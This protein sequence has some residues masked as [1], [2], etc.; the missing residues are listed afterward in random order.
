MPLFSVR[1]LYFAKATVSECSLSL[2]LGANT[3]GCPI[4]TKKLVMKEVFLASA[5]DLYN[6]LTDKKVGHH[7]FSVSLVESVNCLKIDFKKL[8]ILKV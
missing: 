8:C 2:S 7:A 3:I 5:E 6:T 4:S 1:S